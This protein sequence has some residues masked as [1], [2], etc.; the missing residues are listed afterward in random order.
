MKHTGLN[1]NNGHFYKVGA[2]LGVARLVLGP[3]DAERDK[4]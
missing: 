2:H 1:D 3:P 4:P